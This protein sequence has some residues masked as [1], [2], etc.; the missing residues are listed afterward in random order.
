[1][2]FRE[3]DHQL[4]IHIIFVNHKPKLALVGN[5]NNPIYPLALCA[6]TNHKCFAFVII[7]AVE[8][9]VREKT[10]FIPIID[11]GF[12]LFSTGS[13]GPILF[14][15]QFGY[16][17]GVFLIGP[18]RWLLW[19]KI[20]A[21]QLLTNDYDRHSFRQNLL[22]RLLYRYPRLQSK[23]QFELIGLLMLDRILNPYFFAL[24]TIFAARSVIAS[25]FD[26]D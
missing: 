21:V 14:V 20:I 19:C 3:I 16:I 7:A 13:D 15:E 17:F 23:R 22:Y 1:M 5:W 18:A 10:R 8:L 9:T 24:V 25:F 11:I 12:L 2:A 26:F 6:Q 4:R